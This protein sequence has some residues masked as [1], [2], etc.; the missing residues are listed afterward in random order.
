MFV[1][2]ELN[3]YICRGDV[4]NLKQS[5]QFRN[6]LRMKKLLVLL[7]LVITSISFSQKVNKDTLSVGDLMILSTESYYDGMYMVGVGAMVMVFGQTI[8]EDDFSKGFTIVG[9]IIALFGTGKAMESH[10]YNKKAGLLLN[11]NGIGLRIKLSD[12]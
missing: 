10:S 5:R 11:K 4:E 1:L 9:S 12:D 7:M 3:T 2:S 6:I 8:V